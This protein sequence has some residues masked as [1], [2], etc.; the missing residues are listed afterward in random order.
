MV[1]RPGFASQFGLGGYKLLMTPKKDERA[2]QCSRGFSMVTWAMIS[3]DEL[4]CENQV[5]SGTS[6][7]HLD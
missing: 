4:F 2:V 5:G 3:Y 1:S 6:S 7:W